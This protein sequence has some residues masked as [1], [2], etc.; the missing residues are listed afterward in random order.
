MYLSRLSMAIV[1]WTRS[2]ILNMLPSINAEIVRDISEVLDWSL[3]L[4]II[5]SLLLPQILDNPVLADD[6]CLPQAHG[7]ATQH[8]HDH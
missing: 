8:T 1:C 5:S 3:L 4:D 6:H 2:E 7:Q